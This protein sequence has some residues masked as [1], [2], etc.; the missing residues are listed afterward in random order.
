MVSVPATAVPGTRLTGCAMVVTDA[1][2]SR[3]DQ[4]AC[5]VTVGLPEPTL[6]QPLAGVPLGSRPRAAGT[7][8]PGARVSVRD[9][10]EREVCA[11]TA[12]ADGTWSCVPAADLPAGGGRLQVTAT[13]NGV[14]AD[15]EQIRITVG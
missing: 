3:R 13:F 14:S 15:S 6:L 2:G 1:G 8:Y 11:A 12:A 5:T 9:Q 7:A 10:N 4:G